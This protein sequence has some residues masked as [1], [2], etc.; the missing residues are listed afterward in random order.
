MTDSIKGIKWKAG[1]LN[2]PLTQKSLLT[3]PGLDFPRKVRALQPHLPVSP[4]R[5]GDG[6]NRLPRHPIRSALLVTVSSGGSKPPLVNREGPTGD[7][8]GARSGGRRGSH[9]VKHRTVAGAAR[10][11]V[12][13]NPRDI[14]LGRPFT[15]A[16]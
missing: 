14:A 5:W 15:T 12:N 6:A 2:A 10:A 16:G 11:T 3:F 1:A 9:R 4:G 7:G 8:Y 13:V